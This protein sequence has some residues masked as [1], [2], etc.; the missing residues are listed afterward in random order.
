MFIFTLNFVPL[1]ASLSMSI[2]Q[3]NQAKFITTS[4]LLAQ[5][6]ISNIKSASTLNRKRISVGENSGDFGE[7]Y[8]DY[9][10]TENVESTPLIGYYKY[11]IKIKLGEGRGGFVNTFQTFLS[12]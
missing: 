8:P 7:D 9:T 10:Y 4:T 3:A 2:D 5:E 1:L 6:H 11:T 12:L